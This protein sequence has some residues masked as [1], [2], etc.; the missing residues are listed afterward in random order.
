MLPNSA[1]ALEHDG[2]MVSSSAG[3]LWRLYVQDARMLL[4]L[5]VYADTKSSHFFL[6]GRQDGDDGRQR[7]LVLSHQ[8]ADVVDVSAL[9][10]VVLDVALNVLQTH[11]EDPQGPLDR[12]QLRHGQQLDVSRADGRT[13]RRMRTTS[14]YCQ[15]RSTHS[16]TF[17]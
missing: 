11:V 15:Q 2:R 8:S 9:S 14:V 1:T 13:P 7:V 6:Y 3:L 5:L 16:N 10:D 17:L 12:V 4:M